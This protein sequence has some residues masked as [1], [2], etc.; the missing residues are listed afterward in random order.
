MKATIG[1]NIDLK[2]TQLGK[3]NREIGEAMGATEHQV[4]RWRRG[5][6]KPSDR[7]MAALAEILFDGDIAAMYVDHGADA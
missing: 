5:K 7:Y 4:W 6:V 3:T 2:I 1:A